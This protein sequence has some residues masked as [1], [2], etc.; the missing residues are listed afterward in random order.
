MAKLAST[1]ASK[2]FDA[3]I[4][5]LAAEA[6][7]RCEQ[8]QWRQREASKLFLHRRFSESDLRDVSESWNGAGAKPVAQACRDELI[9]LRKAARA[10]ADQADHCLAGFS[11]KEMDV[12]GAM[13][14]LNACSEA[15][16]A[17][18]GED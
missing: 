16:H 6:L 18:L 1:D 13:Q 15:V 10:L 14:G 3:A 9:E 11:I 8:E 7:R 12:T 17:A 4:I 2:E 5:G